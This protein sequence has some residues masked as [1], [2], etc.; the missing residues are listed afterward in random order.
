MGLD[1]ENYFVDHVPI[2]LSFGAWF[3]VNALAL[4]AMF[5]ILWLPTLFISRV[6]PARTLKVE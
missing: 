1:P 6:S 3:A 2:D 5:L 4:L